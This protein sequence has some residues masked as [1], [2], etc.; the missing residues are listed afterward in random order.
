M[1]LLKI[2]PALLERDFRNLWLGM[3]PGVLAMQMYLFTNGYLAFELTGEAKSIGFISMGFG[4]P[5]LAFSLMGGMAAD[6][7]SKRVIL[8]I[9]Q[10]AMLVAAFIM[11]ALVLS[12]II[13]IWHMVL[14]SCVMGT[15]FTFH[16]PARQSFV[17]ELISPARL[18]NAIA[19]S[20]AGMNACRVVGPPLAGWL[21]SKPF[22]DIG[23]VYVIMAVMS[24]VVVLS[25]KRIADRGANAGANDTTGTRAVI[26]GIRYIRSS[27][28][29]LVLLILS[30]APIIF[31]MPI[32]SLMPVFAK[33]VFGVGPKGLGLLMM[34]N[35]IGAVAGSLAVASVRRLNRPG[36]VQLFLG[37][38]LGLSLAIFAFCSSYRIGL[39]MMAIVGIVSSSYLSL[40]A[41]LIMDVS[42]RRYHGRVM[43]VYL[44]TFSALPLGNMILS[45]FADVFSVSLTVGVSGLVLAGIVLLFGLL[46]PAY[47][48]LRF[49]YASQPSLNGVASAYRQER[50]DEL[51]GKNIP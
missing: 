47:R 39:V 12:D 18:V 51:P 43:S 41:T 24:A 15:A 3:L 19:L 22:V 11:A 2:F 49:N 44:F 36:I 38:L 31:G 13:E 50:P 23:G 40:N 45:L 26:D 30:I 37:V 48:S 17:A 1:N 5:M 42:D 8:M 33:K 21:I 32:Q 29:L 46:S 25:L 27:P 4:V 6:R 35:G 14:V 10:T 34:A 20:S 7:Y 16:M 28:A 9:S